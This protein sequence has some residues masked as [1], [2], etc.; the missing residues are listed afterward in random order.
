MKR[1]LWFACFLAS[2]ALL[3]AEDEHFS[4]L[5]V[6]SEVYSNVT[7][8]SVTAT[9]VYFSHTRGLGSAK[10]K[11]LDP[12]L[13]QLF[14]YNAAA[15]MA[16][17]AQRAQANAAYR[18]ALIAAPAPN[19]QG[20][21]PPAPGQRPPEVNNGIPP[22]QISAK[23]VLN[24]PAPNFVVEKWLTP[25]PDTQGKFVLVDFWATWCGP[26]RRSIP[27]LNTLYGMF[28]KRLVVIGVSGE[29]EFEVRRMTTP[30]ISYPVAIDTRQR[31]ASALEVKGIPHAILID[32]Q[33]I[34]RFEG[35]PEY[36]NHDNLAALLEQYGQ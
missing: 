13:Q 27:H 16:A 4:T 25:E 12:N 11:D 22:H 20:P 17:D 26:C 14:H 2:A 29:T 19:R 32:P 10:L 1:I 21:A 9:H 18:Q 3:Q 23:S 30:L 36:L 34:V 8:T 15:A 24:Q 28:R 5:K 35:H 33:G 7:V 6:G 31:M